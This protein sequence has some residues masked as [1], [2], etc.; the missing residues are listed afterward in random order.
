MNL[1]PNVEWTEARLAIFMELTRLDDE[2]KRLGILNGTMAEKLETK[3]T[4]DLNEL[5]AANRRT[6]KNV[7][8]LQKKAAALG[9]IVSLL[10][11]VLVKV[12]FHFW[13]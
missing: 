1:P 5:F 13:K 9:A 12:A 3:F 11:T 6:N 2:A 7:S 10:V 4:K 8:A